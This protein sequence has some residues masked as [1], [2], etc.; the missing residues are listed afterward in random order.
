MII[1][2]CKRYFSLVV[3]PD[4][5]VE[6]RQRKVNYEVLFKDKFFTV[7]V[8]TEWTDVSSTAST[9][10]SSFLASMQLSR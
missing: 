10:L 6:A 2:S 4:L 1:D 3:I 8:K 7:N 5:S 9:R